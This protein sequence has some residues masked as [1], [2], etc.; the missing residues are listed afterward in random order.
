MTNIAVVW[1]LVRMGPLMD[2]EVVA[3]REAALTEAA[4]EL[5]LWS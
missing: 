1:P 4:Y 5:L 2:H 3:L